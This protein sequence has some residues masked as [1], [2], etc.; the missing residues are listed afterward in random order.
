MTSLQKT[1]RTRLL[2]LFDPACTVAVVCVV[3]A[4][5]LFGGRPCHAQQLRAPVPTADSSELRGIFFDSLSDAFVGEKPSL[6][7][8]RESA[9]AAKEKSMIADAAVD[10]GDEDSQD[11]WSSIISAASLEDEVKQV[12]L[13]YDSLIT[14]PGKFNSGGYLSARIDLTVLA[15]L[16]G[17]IA[18]HKGQVR[19]K[20]DA[21]AA[22]DLLG[23]TAANCRA[24]STQ[25]YNEAR[26]RKADLR[27]LL[28]GTGLAGRKGEPITDWS[29]V[30][31]RSPLM[32]Y[33]E[34]LIE[35]LEDD[36]RDEKSVQANQEHVRRRAELLAM[37]GKGS[38]G[39]V[40]RTMNHCRWR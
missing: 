17:V 31:D 18:E 35:T 38:T 4:L 1:Y 37:L 3:L 32:E 26:L 23:R 8:I 16:F 19:W 12:R 9:V 34:T 15:T 11:G 29:A 39:R 28:S 21:D 36:G 10:S 2:A 5:L 20:S 27:D 7:S 33:A 40:M 25:V 22:R 30:A 13:R 14:T 6:A 24:A